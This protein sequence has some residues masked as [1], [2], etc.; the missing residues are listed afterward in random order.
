MNQRGKKLALSGVALQFGPLFGLIGTVIGMIHAFGNLAET[1]DANA[2]ELA[3]NI[4]IALY[5]TAIG[6]VMGIVGIILICISI[7]RIQYRAPWFLTALWVLSVLWLLSF[8]ICTVIGILF[9][10]YLNKHKAEFSE[11]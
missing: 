7:F 4:S 5:T 8:P 11:Q 3:N 6:Y 1:G 9:I 10:L 2:G